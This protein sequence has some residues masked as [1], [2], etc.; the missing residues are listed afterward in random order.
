VD[1]EGW[2]FPDTLHWP[3]LHGEVVGDVL[4]E[5]RYFMRVLRGEAP[6]ISTGQDGRNAL[7]VVLAAQRSLREDRPV[8]LP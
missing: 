7:E 2:K 6:I 4:D 8:K 1:E 5:D 3:Q